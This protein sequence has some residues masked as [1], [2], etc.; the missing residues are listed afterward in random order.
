MSAVDRLRLRIGDNAEGRDALL[1]DLV[2]GAE[3]EFCA[4]CRRDDVPAAAEDVIVRIALIQYN[5]IG[6]EG[7]ASQSY[8]GTS[9]SWEA[10]YPPPLLRAMQRWRKIKIL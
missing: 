3:E 2:A 6:A 7:A 5:R 9:E 8:G 1:A 4:Y 10:D